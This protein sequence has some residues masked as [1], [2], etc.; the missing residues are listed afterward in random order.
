MATRHSTDLGNAS[1]NWL[2]RHPKANRVL[3]LPQG[4]LAYE[5]ARGQRRTLGLTVR[6]Q[7]VSVRAPRWTPE[8]EVQA[9]MQR[10][11][12]WLLE[13][14]GQMAERALPKPEIQA[15][16]D[17][18]VVPYLGAGLCLRVQWR[19]LPPTGRPAKPLPPVC[20]DDTLW[21]QAHT[22]EEVAQQVQLWG[23]QEAQ[24]WLHARLLF[25]AQ[26]MGVHYAQWGLSRAQTRWGSCTA[27]GVVRLNWRLIQLAPELIDYVVVHELAHLR[28]MNHSPQFWEEV[29]RAMPDFA[30]RRVAL[31][32]VR[33]A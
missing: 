11:A 3:H 7:G 17:G 2:S 20:I 1:L 13:K 12:D 31:K 23:W 32:Q 6:P 28:H 26:A 22:S 5:F 29:R 15:W 21:V 25:W 4:T 27:S 30:S 16:K 9:F 33:L 24:R 10:K 19:P 8:A 18:D 14:I